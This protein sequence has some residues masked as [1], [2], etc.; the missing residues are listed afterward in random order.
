MESIY[1]TILELIAHTF[2]TIILLV[3]AFVLGFVAYFFFGGAAM[4]YTT[5]GVFFTLF[6]LFVVGLALY[7]LKS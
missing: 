4:F 1:K 5:L 3:F 2:I 6:M 7:S